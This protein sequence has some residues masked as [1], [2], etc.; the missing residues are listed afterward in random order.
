MQKQIF[1]HLEDSRINQ[2]FF[3]KTFEDV[4]DVITAQ[5]I[6]KAVELITDEPDIACFIVDYKLHDGDGLTF[7]KKIRTVK[8]YE[9]VPVI[10]LTSTLTDEIERDAQNVGVNESLDKMISNTDLRKVLADQINNPHIR[11]IRGEEYRIPCVTYALKAKYYQFCPAIEQ[12]VEADTPEKA[13]VKMRAGLKEALSKR[14]GTINPVHAISQCVHV[15]D[16]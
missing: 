7:V 16:G 8:K 14:D 3:Q 4:A 6:V 1:F 11:W 9:A 5:S 10:L 15:I 13:E 12:L 2:I